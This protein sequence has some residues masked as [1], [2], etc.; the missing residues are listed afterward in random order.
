MFAVMNEQHQTLCRSA[1]WATLLQDEI[2]GPLVSGLELGEELLELG[3]G[4]GA[5]TE[6]FRHRV[7]HLVALE[8]DPEAAALL[9]AAYD[10][11]NVEVLVGDC[12][13]MPFPGSSF[14]SVASFTMLHH[15]P[16][17]A[18]QHATLA[19]AFRVLR[20]GGLLV[21]ADSLASP[22]LHDFHVGDTYNPIDPARLL[23]ALQLLGYDPITVSVGCDVQFTARK[24]KESAED[25]RGH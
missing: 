21:G 10:T 5:S 17:A 16:S 23:V 13:R 8:L 9:H 2:I 25:H 12:T 24:P 18:A 22:E 1:E 4:P 14:D 15:L 11:T 6:W 20:P 7:D 19:E 3:P